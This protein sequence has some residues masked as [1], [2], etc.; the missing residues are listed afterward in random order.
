MTQLILT[1]NF[2][3]SCNPAAGDDQAGNLSSL[4]LGPTLPRSLDG[5]GPSSDPSPCGAG[6]KKPA[7]PSYSASRP[8]PLNSR[9][10]VRRSAC[11]LPLAGQVW[12][13][14]AEFGVIS[15]SGLVPQHDSGLSERHS[16][17]PGNVPADALAAAW[18]LLCLLPRLPSSLNCLMA[19]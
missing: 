9:L 7:N 11:K 15:R 12:W 17:S 13:S 6:K 8:L 1:A 14:M 5:A 19:V 10:S 4:A 16:W 2:G 3:L 18:R